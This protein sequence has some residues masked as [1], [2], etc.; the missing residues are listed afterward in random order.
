MR[1][2]LKLTLMTVAI[3]LIG[4]RAMAMAPVINDLPSPIVGNAEPVTGGSNFVYIDAFDL[5]NYG[6][7]VETPTN[8]L[9][10]SYTGPG[11]A[12]A[13]K[14][15]INGVAPINL[16]TVDPTSPTTAQCINLSCAV[17]EWNPDGKKNTVTIRNNL[18]SPLQAG[19]PSPGAFV[20]PG[21]GWPKSHTSGVDDAWNKWSIIDNYTATGIMAGHGGVKPDP[22]PGQTEPVYFFC[23]DGAAYTSQTVFFYSAKSTADRLSQVYTPIIPTDKFTTFWSANK[24]DGSGTTD[25]SGNLTTTSVGGM[26]F[27]VGAGGGTVLTGNNMGSLASRMPYFSL[28]KNMVYRIRLQMNGSQMGPGATPFWDFVLEN[29]ETSTGRGLNLY[30]MD[31]LVFD[32]VGGANSVTANGM[33]VT[34]YWTPAA[35][36]TA[37]WNNSTTGLF[38]AQY[39]ANKDPRLRFR[40]LD[41]D[42]LAA[43]QSNTKGGTL[44]IQSLSIDASDISMCRVLKNLYTANTMVKNG[45]TGGNVEVL[46]LNPENATIVFAGGNVTC[47]GFDHWNG[48]AP[49]P[50]GEISHNGQ[51][52]ESVEVRP[53]TD[54]IY[55]EGAPWATSSW[56]DNWPIAWKS[57]QILRLQV[58]L[59]APN[60]NSVTHPWDAIFL[61]FATLTNE[62]N[63]DSFVTTN[64]GI[65]TPQM[66]T[67]QTYTAFYWT[68]K[69]TIAADA[70]FHNL[71]WRVRFINHPA[72]FFPSGNPITDAVN[73]GG[74]TCSS[75][76][77]DQV[78]FSSMP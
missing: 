56:A 9:L 40:V 37:Q 20:E 1:K 70:Q 52:L 60:A 62:V 44:C 69:E 57:G 19:E 77:V 7:D 30:S 47:T 55:G 71:R 75:V 22:A 14:Y 45:T 5:N 27:V 10:W 32:N 16:N 67:P 51:L 63:M 25:W 4:V 21:T 31:T 3:A 66:G 50:G 78:T 12:G 72:A 6:S 35:V 29:Y 36:A 59:S 58:G 73:V 49:A 2:G 43:S 53:A 61:S 41:L 64:K 18:L 46:A 39:A 33:L 24:V 17:N 13:S 38:T 68:Q 23:S 48:F 8:E 28:A 11:T 15:R 26:C 42:D 65:A 34:M 74:V 76:K 54:T